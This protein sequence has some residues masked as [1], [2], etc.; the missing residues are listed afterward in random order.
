MKF[1]RLINKLL[2]CGSLVGLTWIP[3]WAQDTGTV[4]GKVTL[5]E[6]SEPV[7]GAVVL[8]VEAGQLTLT[9]MT[10]SLIHI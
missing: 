6:T 3:L 2:I 8:V 7:H 1:L 10:L 9:E 5:V 4:Q